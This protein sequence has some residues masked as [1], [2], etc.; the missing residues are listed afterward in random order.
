VADI[1]LENAERRRE[2]LAADI[3]GLQQQIEQKRKE[4]ERVNRFIEEYKAYAAGTL[5]FEFGPPAAQRVRKGR[6]TPNLDRRI[7]GDYA[8][9]ILK[10]IGRP[11]PREE[12]FAA[13]KKQGVDIFGTDPLMVFSTMMWRMPNRFVRLAGGHGYW[14]R[15]EPWPAAGYFPD[16]VEEK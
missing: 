5:E 13:L 8:E 11:M 14:L 6:K 15:N 2:A 3:N 7:I 4:L 10:E 9:A 12:L 16:P 1:A